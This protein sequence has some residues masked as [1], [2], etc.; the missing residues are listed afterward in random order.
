MLY[1]NEFESGKLDIDKIRIEFPSPSSL[2][3]TNLSE[4]IQNSQSIIEFLT[5]TT[6]GEQDDN[7]KEQYN[8]VKKAITKDMLNQFDWTKYETIANEILSP[9]INR[10]KLEDKLKASNKDDSS[11]GF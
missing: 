4:Q 1:I 2:N 8:A 3:M 10:K 5:N 7:N 9:D 6:V 11:G